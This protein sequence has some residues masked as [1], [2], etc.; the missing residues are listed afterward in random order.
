MAIPRDTQSKLY[1]LSL[2]ECAWEFPN[3]ASREILSQGRL[4]STA[5]QI[6]LHVH[7][8]GDNTFS[9]KAYS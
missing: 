9:V 1:K 7:V 5:Q 2:T 3:N 8:A 6:K 4:N